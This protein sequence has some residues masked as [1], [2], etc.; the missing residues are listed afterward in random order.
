MRKLLL[1]L[2]LAA[3]PVLADNAPPATPPVRAS[4]VEPDRDVG[5][6]VGDVLTRKIRLEVKKPYE[7][8]KT[9]LPIVGYERRYKNQVTGIEVVR[10]GYEQSTS[11]DNNVYDLEI[12]YQV[13][14]NNVVA[15]PA[16]LPAETVKFAAK[17]KQFDYRIPS[18][19]FR[20]SPL[21]VF[22]QVVVEKDMSPLR[23]PLLLD[24]TPHQRWLKVLLGIMGTALLGLVYVL[25]AH[26]WL[27]R[28][29]GPFARAYR[30]LRKLPATDDGLRQAVTRVHEA[31]NKTAGSSVFNTTGFLE[32]KP[33]F[34]PVAGQLDQFFRLSRHVFFEPAAAHGLEEAP[35]AWLRNFCRA[36]RNCE[37][38]M[39]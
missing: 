39:K 34:V 23:G 5:Y 7:L 15:K 31:L 12:S 33:G 8:V 37:R 3:S 32:S 10:S 17:G 21:A 36:C 24:P 9:S 4:I 16:A 19:G 11:G 18:F 38:G 27:P 22:G 25:G 35:I 1:L 30:A 13:F 6:T 2:L 28:M 29:G 26:T 14:T 20:V